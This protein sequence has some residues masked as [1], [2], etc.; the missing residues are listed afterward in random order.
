MSDDKII[1]NREKLK[2][3][4]TALKEL[5]ASPLNADGSLFGS[6]GAGSSDNSTRNA[7]GTKGGGTFSRKSRKFSS[8]HKLKSTRKMRR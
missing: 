6:L 5:F 4:L 3:T 7:K 8:Y 1:V 2:S